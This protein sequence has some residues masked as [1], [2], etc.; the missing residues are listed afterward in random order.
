MTIEPNSPFR[1]IPIELKKEQVILFDGLQYC[2][3]MIDLT[4]D[5]LWRNLYAFNYSKSELKPSHISIFA[6]A[7]QF[8]NLADT[9][10]NIIKRFGINPTDPLFDHFENISL[11]RNSF[12]HVDER[13]YNIDKFED[14][15]AFGSLS[16][17]SQEKN[18][19]FSGKLTT[20]Y[21]GVFT[22]KSKAG[23]SRTTTIGGGEGNLVRGIQLKGITCPKGEKPSEKVVD[24]SELYSRIR[25]IIGSLENQVKAQL[26]KSISGVH[27][28]NLII[29]MD[30]HHDPT[31]IE[32]VLN[33]G[34]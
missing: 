26:P 34:N 7:W 2:V 21:A 20:L 28:K 25:E 24:L 6:D 14:M 32:K 19:D 15:P 10:S 31:M 22:N 13:L 33:Q 12:Q 5:R 18:E 1:K 9:L 17:Y 8:T 29:W 23:T 3:D 4:F 27:S 11:L 30:V 16:W